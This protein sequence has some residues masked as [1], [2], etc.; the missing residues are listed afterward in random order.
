MDDKLMSYV[1]F[2]GGFDREKFIHEIKTF[3]EA[4]KAA[5]EKGLGEFKKINNKRPTV[6]TLNEYSDVELAK[7]HRWFWNSL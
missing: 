1:N 6:N 4:S 7:I 3:H 5:G 2:H